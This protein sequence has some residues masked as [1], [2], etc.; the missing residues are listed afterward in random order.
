MIGVSAGGLDAL[1]TVLPALPAGFALPVIVVQH[2]HPSQDSSQVELLAPRCRLTVKEAQDK[3][4]VRPGYVYTAPADYHLLVEPD[5]TFSLSIDE[6]V[7]YARPS[8]DVL[9]ES[10]VSVWGAALVGVVLTGANHD[11]ANGLRQIRQRGGLAIVQD[12]ATAQHPAMPQ[13]ALA[14]AKPDC[15]LPL[16]EIGPFLAQLAQCAGHGPGAVDQPRD[17]QRP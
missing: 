2:L 7:S 11:G 16:A 12:P 17:R 8:I 5:E 3:E 14:A 1:T 4:P 9:F 13:A 10:A 6:R 15:V